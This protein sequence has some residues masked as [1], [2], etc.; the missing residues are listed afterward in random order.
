M[1]IIT[2]FFLLLFSFTSSNAKEVRNM[3]I[4]CWGD[5]LTYGV[6]SQ[7][8]NSYPDL[9]RKNGYDVIKKGYPGQSSSDIAMRQGGYSPIIKTSLISTGVYKVTSMEPS[10]DFRKYKEMS[11]YGTLEGKPV[12]LSRGVD[13]SWS[14][15]SST[16]INCGSGCRFITKEGSEAKDAVNIIWVGR[17]NNLAFPRFAERDIDLIVTSLPRG[18]RFIIVGITPSRT[19]SEEN[20]K[21][22]KTINSRLSMRYGSRFVDMW[23]ILSSE[24]IKLAGI[25]PSQDDK[26]ASSNGL[27]PPSLYSDGIHF[28]DNGYKAISLI[29]ERYI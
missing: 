8:G 2:L 27:I 4:I 29:I 26:D 25:S 6:G 24:G 15:N 18:N 5:S 21:A 16:D 12:I 14:V 19:D 23:R 1:K 17:N 28:N 13:G 9:L 11:F 10:G 20:I 3:I 22:I 7:S